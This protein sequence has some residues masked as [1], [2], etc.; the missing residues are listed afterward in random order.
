MSIR[1]LCAALFGFVLALA[2]CIKV[3]A[4]EIAGNRLFPA[5]L[6]TDDPGVNDELAVPT[7]SYFKNGDAPPSRQLDISGEYSKRITDAFAISLGSTWTHLRPAWLPSVS[8]FQ[9]LETSFKYRLIKDPVHELIVSVGLS[10]EWGGT[11]SARVGAESFNTYTPTLF[12]GKGFGD[13]P[14]TAMW[15]RPIAVTGQFGYA[16]PGRRTTTTFGIDPDTGDPTA[17]IEHNPHFLV[18]GDHC[19]TACFTSNR[20]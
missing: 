4:H 13:L 11:G 16:I 15:L 20:P 19:N 14:D 5:T 18:W 12:F 2:P 10:V 8:G 1:T 9:N 17:D 7:I 6:A 3:H